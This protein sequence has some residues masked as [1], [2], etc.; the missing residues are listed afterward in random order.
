[1]SRGDNYDIV[2][3]LEVMIMIMFV[4]RGDDYDTVVSSG[5]DCYHMHIESCLGALHTF[6][7]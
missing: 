4:S 6:V 2:L 7:K 3:Y 1:M 5:D